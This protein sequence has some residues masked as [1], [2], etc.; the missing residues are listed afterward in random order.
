MI[1]VAFASEDGWVP[2]AETPVEGVELLDDGELW[3][4]PELYE[5]SEDGGELTLFVKK[6]KPTLGFA[7][8]CPEEDDAG[9]CGV[10]WVDDQ[11]RC[12]HH[13]VL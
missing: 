1:G 3:I 9:R 6:K 11:P 12:P 10:I 8:S 4:D 2:L 13:V 7:C 5:V